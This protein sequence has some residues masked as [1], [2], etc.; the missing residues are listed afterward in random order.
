VARGGVVGYDL[1]P[2]HSVTVPFKAGAFLV[3][4]TDGV[5]P[6][7]TAELRA[8]RRAQQAADHIL[9]SYG[10]GTDDA[11]VMVLQLL[12]GGSDHES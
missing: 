6:G 12:R 3:F 1:P 9:A 5:R 10:R 11:L 8:G 2:S 7:F 4:A